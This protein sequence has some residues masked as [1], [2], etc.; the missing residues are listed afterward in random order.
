VRIFLGFDLVKL[1][2]P[3]RGGWRLLRGRR[4]EHGGLGDH[5]EQAVFHEEPGAAIARLIL[6]PD[7]FLHAAI[8]LEKRLNFLLREGIQLLDA[9]DRR[10]RYLMFLAAGVRARRTLCRCRAASG[11]RARAGDLPDRR[12]RVGSCLRS[13]LPAMRSTP[14][15]GEG[16]WAS[17]RSAACGKPV[18]SAAGEDG[19]IGRA[20]SAA[21]LGGYFRRRARGIARRSRWSARGPGLRSRAGGASSRPQNFCHLLSAPAMN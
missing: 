16:S 9:R 1:I 18:S 4:T 13:V 19:N 7:D 10:I 8:F 12:E 11:A 3:G 6:N 5:A 15:R 21:R 20:G 17:S 2:R 14:L